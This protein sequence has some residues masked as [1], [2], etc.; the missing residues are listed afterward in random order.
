[1]LG[2]VSLTATGWGT[3]E[4]VDYG[5]DLTGVDAD[6][7]VVQTVIVGQKWKIITKDAEGK[8]G[9][10]YFAEY[11]STTDTVDLRSEV[12]TFELPAQS[13]S[14]AIVGSVKIKAN[15][16][17]DPNADNWVELFGAFYLGI[18]PER[19]EL[20]VNAEVRINPLGISGSA[21]GLV[22]IDASI[23]GPGIP[24]IAMF[25]SVE[26]SVGA[27]PESGEDS[28]VA[29]LSGIFQL[30]GKVRVALNTTLRE[31]VF[32]VP[33]MFLPLMPEDAPTTITIYDN[34]PDLDGSRATDA[35]VSPSIYV[36]ASIEGAITLF[37]TITLTG[38]IGFTASVDTNLNAFI[39]ISGA[40]STKIEYVGALS[41][42][43]DLL[44]YTNLDG[45]G[46]GIMGRVQLAIADGGA[47]PG[48]EIRGQF[49]L[50]VNSFGSDKTI[51]S[52][53]TNREADPG[54]SGSQPDILATDPDTGLFVIG[55]VT[56]EAGLRLVLA[57][58]LVL[59]PVLEIEGRFEFAISTDPFF[60]E[61]KALAKMKLLGVGEFDID[62]VLRVD[63][64]G[65]AAFINVDISG[66][67]GG[68]LGLQFNVGATLELYIGSL[69]EKILTRAD[70]TTVAVK[71]GFRLTL[72][73]SVSFLGFAEASGTVIITLQADVFSLEFDISLNLGP[74]TV[75]ARGGAAVYLP[76]RLPASP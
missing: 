73:G 54:Y 50:E 55:D 63:G 7:S 4:L 1:V 64:D 17:S 8:F 25:L 33:D 5:L 3:T 35:G 67:F 31:Q 61:I 12:Q 22:I 62:A 41:G 60:I 28:G 24:G 49:L 46:P 76:G 66:G 53:Q 11:N 13:F 72:E 40:V 43:L 59:G 29:D 70:G 38:F 39:R 52:F 14:I 15:G 42:S 71:Q 10:V 27:P 30:E 26:L 65:F 6:A 32:T 9:L 58:K 37:D 74:L 48:I 75:S 18:T 16:S 21:V 47:I 45:Q 44:F 2:E 68:D 36:S 23:D 20:F 34:A 56:I 57:G 19:F 69:N 51:S